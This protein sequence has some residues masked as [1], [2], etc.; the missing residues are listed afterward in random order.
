MKIKKK[1]PSTQ[2]PEVMYPA[3]SNQQQHVKE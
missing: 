1:T 3:A 2:S